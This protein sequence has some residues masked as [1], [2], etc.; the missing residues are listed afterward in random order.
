MAGE[1]M[2]AVSVSDFKENAIEIINFWKD[3]E[4]G[5][6]ATDKNQKKLKYACL[7]NLAKIYLLLDDFDSSLNYAKLVEEGDYKS[8]DGKKIRKKIEKTKGEI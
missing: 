1:L 3:K 8:K 4:S 7:I 5:Y 2:T 6:A